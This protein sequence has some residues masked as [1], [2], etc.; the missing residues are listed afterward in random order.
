M[1]INTLYLLY[2]PGRGGTE[3]YVYSLATSLP[4]YFRP[5]LAYGRPGPLVE[6][7]RQAGLAAFHVP[8]RH[9]LDPLAVYRL[10]RLMARERVRVTHSNFLR[11]NFLGALASRLA[12]VPVVVNT[13]HMLEPPPPPVALANRVMSRLWDGV[14]AVSEAVARQVLAQGLP[15]EKVRVILNGVRLERFDVGG[16]RQQ[17]REGFGFG[18]DELVIGSV[19]RLAPEKGFDVL[20]EAV[21][22]AASRLNRHLRVLIAGDGPCRAQLEAQARRLRLGPRV[23]FVGHYQDIPR[24]LA[25]LDLFVLPSRHEACSLALLEALAAGVPVIASRTGGNVE[26]IGESG[27]A[28]L[29]PPGQA[30]ELANAICLLATDPELRRRLGRLGRERALHFSLERMVRETAQLYLEILERKHGQPPRG[31]AL[32]RA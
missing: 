21:A 15:A 20:L 3:E 6:R 24:A 27:A 28:L 29:V 2:Y 31:G 18:A 14:I 8:M 22:V 4:G 26:V 25:A 5:L 23:L 17:A 1:T 32:P 19:G 9:P 16:S 30:G 11:E 12:G 10:A 7:W 13:V